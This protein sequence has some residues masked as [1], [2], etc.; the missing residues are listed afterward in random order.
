MIIIIAII[1]AVSIERPILFNDFSK[2]VLSY[3][4]SIT[5]LLSLIV[6][7]FSLRSYLKLFYRHKQE[8]K[9]VQTTAPVN[10]LLNRLKRNGMNR[11]KD[12]VAI[13]TGGSLGLGKAAAKMMSREGA[14][15]VITDVLDE[16]G[17]KLKEEINSEGDISLYLHMDVSKEEEV[18]KVFAEASEKFGHIDILVNNAGISGVNKPTDEIEVEDWQRV[19]DVNV[20]GVF[21]CT[22]HVIPYLRKQG[23]GSI[24]NLSS[25]YGLV[26][27]SDVPPYHASKGAVRLMTKT[28]ALLYAKDQIRV[29][30]VHPGYIWTP[31]VEKF[32]ESMGADMEPFIK[33]VGELHPL[34]HMGE[35]DDIAYGI[36]FLASD[37]SKFITGSEL[38][39]DGGYTCR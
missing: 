30:S 18:K 13:I 38:V 28:D 5:L 33:Q 1:P 9:K 11:L 10:C 20:K 31:M 39:I 15:V 21:L 16:E 19:M 24:I 22:K 12:K 4:I 2:T 36:V 34:G 14:K 32:G 6:G 23:K 29:N 27:G 3:T 25:I 37:E 35:P 17:I 26:G 8:I 7:F